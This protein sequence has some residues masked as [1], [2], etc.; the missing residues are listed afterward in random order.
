MYIYNIYIYV[1]RSTDTPI[2]PLPIETTDMRL[3]MMALLESVLSNPLY[4]HNLS[5]YT[6]TILRE[7]LIPNTVW[8]AGRV[9]S[10]VRKVALVCLYTLLEDQRIPK[11][12]LYETVPELLPILKTD[13]E[14][15]DA[16]S[17]ELVVKSLEQI[18]AALPMAFGEEPIRQ[19]YPELLKRLDDSHDD[20]RTSVCRTMEKFLLAGSPEI[21]RSGILDYMIDQLLIHLD[22]QDA[23]IQQAVLRVLKVAMG[24]DGPMVKKKVEAARPCQRS[25]KLCDEI[26]EHAAM[27][28]VE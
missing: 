8:R 23:G 20:V 21:F 12:V 18:F 28:V 15:Y 24:V 4:N 27:S 2:L 14:D 10:T 25:P 11:E 26:L 3:S 7:I 17:R 13:M 1:F 19:L 9:A 16:S 22:D 5:G 6:K